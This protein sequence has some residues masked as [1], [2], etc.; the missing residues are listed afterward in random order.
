MASPLPPPPK[1]KSLESTATWAVAVVCFVLVAI[2]IVIEQLL[3]HTELW[4]KKKRKIALCEALEKIKAELMLLGFISL[5]LTVTQESLSDICVPKTVASSW[6][7]CN[8]KYNKTYYDPCLAKGKAQLVSAYGIHQLHI[9]I[10]VLALAHVIYCIVTYAFG[11]LKMRQWKAW[12]D[13]TKTVEYQYYNDPDRFRFARETSFGRRHLH[14]WSRSP[15]LLWIVCFFRQFFPSVAKVDYLTLRHGF[16][17]EH[18]PPQVQDSFDFQIYINR[19]LEDDFKVIVGISPALW[20][21]AVLL[22]L[23]NTNGWYSHF[24]L[25]LIPLAII[26]LVGA[27]LQVIITKMGTRI[28]ERGDVVMGSPVVHPSDD[29]FWFNRPRLILSLIHFVL[30]ENA[31]Q[32]ALFAWSWLK[33]GYPSCYHEHLEDMIIRIVMGVVIQVLCSYV[34]LPL[35]ALVTQMGSNMKP[36]IFSDDVVL[37]LRSWQATAN[38]HVNEGRPS[39]IATTFSSRPTSPMRMSPAYLRHSRKRSSGLDS[40]G[41]G[42]ERASASPSRHY[43]I[44]DLNK[45]DGLSEIVGD[46]ENPTPRE[47]DTS[48]SEFS[49]RTKDSC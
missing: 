12:E 17:T 30:F 44:Q 48:S 9:F 33:F 46:V 39:A 10:F 34:T 16:V 18:L 36:V 24:W 42:G 1:E 13:E 38:K 47:V 6:H 35:Y 49:F 15:I 21:C 31:F 14:F 41:R 25:P 5:L 3:H 8:E 28:L 20:F 43:N 40:E 7:P 2:S 45:I 4:L 27:K 11:I 32:I 29:L 22:L 37:A 26:L 23:T 19:A